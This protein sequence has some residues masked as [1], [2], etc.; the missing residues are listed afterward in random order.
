MGS[1]GSTD[2]GPEGG[3]TWPWLRVD[4]VAPAPSSSH[5]N[6]RPGRLPDGPRVNGST[7]RP[8][9]TSEVLGLHRLLDGLEQLLEILVDQLGKPGSHLPLV[10]SAIEYRDQRRF[11]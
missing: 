5:A 10:C 9:T 3:A 1:A 6:H 11:A 4:T 8:L 7:G 2:N